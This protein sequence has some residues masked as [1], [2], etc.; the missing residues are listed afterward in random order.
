MLRSWQFRNSEISDLEICCIKMNSEFTTWKISESTNWKLYTKN[1]RTFLL[2][3]SELSWKHHK[4]QEYT[5]VIHH[6]Q[7]VCPTRGNYRM[8]PFWLQVCDIYIRLLFCIHTL[9]PDW[10]SAS[11]TQCSNT[12]TKRVFIWGVHMQPEASHKNKNLPSW[13]HYILR[14]VGRGCFPS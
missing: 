4:H 12:E 13:K 1:V 14:A 9:S 10:L 2:W 5:D 11:S 8:P 7:P 3:G 6:A